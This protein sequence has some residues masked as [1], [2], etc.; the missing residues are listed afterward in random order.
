MPGRRGCDGFTGA[1]RMPSGR[2]GRGADCCAGLLRGVARGA[3]ARGCRAG[4]LRG[5]RGGLLRGVALLL[6]R[7]PQDFALL[8]HFRRRKCARDPLGARLATR[9]VASERAPKFPSTLVLTG[10]A[11]QPSAELRVVA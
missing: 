10:F 6:A 1:I 5:L 2:A 3:A 8:V 11:A 4:L 9:L 7:R